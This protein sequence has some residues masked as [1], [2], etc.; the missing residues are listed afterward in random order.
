MRATHGDTD[1]FVGGTDQERLSRVIRGFAGEIIPGTGHFG[2]VE[3]PYEAVA[4]LLG[5]SR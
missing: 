3:R 2:H 1:V 4:T 5:R